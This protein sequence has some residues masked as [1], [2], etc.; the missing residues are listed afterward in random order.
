MSAAE[1]VTWTLAHSLWQATL[2]AALFAALD[3]AAGPSRARLR[4]GA[5]LATLAVQAAAPVLTFALLWSEAAPQGVLPLGGAAQTA[6]PRWVASAWGVG[7]ALM[8][9]R[10]CAGV[11]G[12][13][14]L[15][16]RAHPLRDEWRLRLEALRARVGVRK[17]VR[18]L[19]SWLCEVPVTVGHLR[20]VVL[21]PVSALAGLSVPELELL[22]AHELWHV[23]RWDYL[24]NLL[25][26]VVEAALFFHPAVWW[27]SA[28]VRAEREACCDDGVVRA[29]ADPLAYARAL[30]AL[31]AQRR[32]KP[33]ELALASNGGALMWRV[34]RLVQR[35]A[36][37]RA[38]ASAWGVLSAAAVVLTAGWVLAAAPSARVQ[39]PWLPPALEPYRAEIEGAAAKAQ[40][41]ADLLAVMVLAESSA[42]PRAVS[43]GGAR[44]LLQLMPATAQKLSVARGLPYAVERLDEP[45]FNLELG[46][47]YLAEQLARF[48]SAEDPVA[49]AVAAYNA[50]P[51]K[52]EAFTQG[53]G[54]LPAETQGYQR[55]VLGMWRERAASRSTAFEAWR[56]RVLGKV[57]ARAVRPVAG[58]R[59]TLAYGAQTHPFD[60]KP[61]EH[62]GVD[63]P[64]ALGTPVLAP[65]DGVVKEVSADE[66]RGTVV[67]L[68]H[69]GG[70]QTRYHHLGEVQ[71]RAEQAIK[72]GQPFATVGTT[73]KTTG[74]HVHYEVVDLGRPVDPAGF[75]R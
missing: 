52:V 54:A 13:R 53:R 18:W 39:S 72:Q 73:G 22:V 69:K 58:A 68:Q 26:S 16:A 29:G 47:R 10:L 1:L 46:A 5:A 66:Q 24:V 31:E 40:V 11:W 55:L 4:Y 64:A 25:Q 51:E 8:G 6:V 32:A 7:A 65:L 61:Y 21:I 43:P 62:A 20:P 34:K 45:A 70:L 59:V 23:R 17:P 60:G 49:L 35:G 42:D 63:L 56:E 27:V 38:Q 57:A 15:V 37:P 33:G 28:R 75:L 36:A 30:T 48:A 19:A 41:D 74:P 2:A 14:R 44:G 9:L 50:G 67:V 12:V 3:L 71:V